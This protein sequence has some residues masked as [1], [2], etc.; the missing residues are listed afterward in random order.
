MLFSWY[1]AIPMFADLKLLV[2][3]NEDFVLLKVYDSINF[4]YFDY[5]I[6]ETIPVIVIVI[7]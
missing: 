2:L 3:G 7:H 5:L 6:L 1:N 4:K